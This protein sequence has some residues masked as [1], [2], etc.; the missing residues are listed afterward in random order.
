LFCSLLEA[1]KVETAFVTIP[2]HIYMAFAIGEESAAGAPEGFPEGIIN[3]GG[4]AW[5]PLE[6][7]IPAEGFY[8]AWRVGLREWEGAAEETRRIYPIREA[9]AVYPSVSVPGAGR[10][11][12]TLPGE[13][14]AAAAFERG[15]RDFSARATRMR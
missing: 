14:E 13:P 7:T 6:I 3:H 11:T 5:M 10:R 8:R 15:L 12:I 4:K 2:G 9:W 1:L